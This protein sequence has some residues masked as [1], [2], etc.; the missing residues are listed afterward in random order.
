MSKQVLQMKYHPAKKEV[1]FHRFQ[2]GVEIP[3]RPDSK[4]A[5]YMK[6]KGHF[7]L[8]DHGNAFFADIAE[9]FDGERIIDIGVITTKNDYED[10]LQMIEYFNGDSLVRINA[11]LLAELPDMDATY[12]AVK[13]HGKKSISILKKHQAKFFEID[14]H[15]PDVKGVV[16]N[17]AADVHKEVNS[18]EEKINATSKNNV[19]LCFVGVFSAGKSALINSLLGYAIL[20]VGINSET[21]KMFRIQS[22]KAGEKVRII[23]SIRANY[24]EL[25][26]DENKCVFEFATKLTENSS[27]K[28]LQG[29]VNENKKE[30]LHRQ[31]YEILKILNSDKDISIDIKVFF[32]VPLDDDKVQFTIYDTPGTDSDKDEHKTVLEEAL[33]E[34]THSILIF[35]AAPN[36]MEGEGNNALL[37]YLK[38]AEKKDIKTSIDIGRSLFVINWADSIGRE[39]RIDLQ[40]AKIKDKV[41]PDFSIKLSDKKLFFTSAKIAYAAKAKQNGIATKSEEFTILQNNGTI[42]DPVFG[43]FYQQNHCATS[44]YL[45]KR[46]IELSTQELE[47]A[48]MAKDIPEVLHV[49]SGVFALENEI[50][51]YG[52]KFAAA[53]KAFA[54]IDSVDKALSKMKT[55]AE[56]LEGK[57]KQNIEEVDKAMAEL[58]KTVSTGIQ[59]AYDQSVVPSNGELPVNVLTELHLNSDYI[60]R[61]FIEEPMS[62]FEKLLD[63][64]LFEWLFGKPRFNEKHKK[65]ITQKITSIVSD[66]TRNF[67]EKRK[68]LLEQQRDSFIATVKNIIQQNGRLSDEEKKFVCEIR[69][70]KVNEASAE[71]LGEIFD[72]NVRVDK[73][74]L[75]E[76]KVVNKDD[77]ISEAVTKL[78]TMSSGLRQDF[79]NDYRESL[80]S[81]YTAVASEFKQNLDKY[82]VLMKAMLKE[83]DALEQLRIKI[84]AAAQELLASQEELNTII[85]S[86]KKDEQ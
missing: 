1:E 80:C 69:S 23:F 14:M 16:E 29:V 59:T 54:I 67:L 60:K 48:E 27:R 6:E 75:F 2:S 66:F 53:V 46:M 11:T 7:V 70:P 64:G 28:K 41:D 12:R 24:A 50:K 18:I 35:V 52:E 76:I 39:E 42:S 8:Q 62:F 33:S 31:I 36:R 71:E 25:I 44:E 17:F 81:I 77:F 30:P 3:I 58:Q 85:W 9:T 68:R 15:N 56:A 65:E 51:L 78:N 32:R 34:Q 73:I 86:V 49:C 55:N 37:N 82:S 13:D 47:K 5:P 10:F 84:A 38:E 22:P 79:E 20:P 72:A 61:V 4:L 43:R 57:A 21:A 26:W 19:N 45:T 63:G 74:L 83:K 40:K